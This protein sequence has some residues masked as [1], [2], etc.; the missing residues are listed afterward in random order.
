MDKKVLLVLI[1]GCVGLVLADDL[2]ITGR[3][4]YSAF[5]WRS[6]GTFKA[7]KMP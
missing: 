4:D 6:S 2:V 1:G 5:T 7:D 3:W